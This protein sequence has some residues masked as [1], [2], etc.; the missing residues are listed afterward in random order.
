MRRSGYT[1]IDV[2]ASGSITAAAVLVVMVSLILGVAILS[3]S[4]LMAEDGVAAGE[5]SPGGTS[6]STSIVFP[7]T[8]VSDSTAAGDGEKGAAKEQSGFKPVWESTMKAGE[9]DVSLGTSMKTSY[10]HSSGWTFMNSVNVNKTVKRGRDMQR[11]NKN[12]SGTVTRASRGEYSVKFS[13]GENYNKSTS[14]GLARYGKALVMDKQRADAEVI[15]KKGLIPSIN[16][17]FSFKGDLKQGRDDFKYDRTYVGSASSFMGYH[18]TDQLMVNGSYGYSSTKESSDVG[19]ITFGGMPSWGD[20]MRTRVTYGKGKKKLVDFR[21]R[22]SDA[23]ERSVEPPRGQ[24]L[25]ILDDPSKAV[26]EEIVK[27]VEEINLTSFTQPLPYVSLEVQ[28][29]RS[30]NS[31]R[32]REEARMSRSNEKAELRAKAVYD[33][34]TSGA[35]SFTITNREEVNLKGEGSKSSYR[36]E[37]RELSAGINQNISK[38]SFISLRGTAY[39]TQRFFIVEQDNPRDEDRVFYKGQL[40]FQAE[41]FPSISTLISATADKYEIINI[42]ESFSG[43]NRVE[44]LYLIEPTIEFRPDSWITLQQDYTIRMEYTDY[45]YTADKNYLQRT[46]GL[47][48]SATLRVFKPLGLSFKYTYLL[49]D[50]GSYLDNERGIEVYSPYQENL[51]DGLAAALSYNFSKD[52]QIRAESKFRLK[53]RNQIGSSGGDFVVTSSTDYESG[54]LLLGFKKYSDLSGLGELDMDIAYIK[55]YGPYISEKRKEYWDV[56]ASLKFSF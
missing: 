20:T 27:E 19:D 16:S 30:I 12:L 13:L 34:S 8:S 55:N 10:L 42:D 22:Q 38:S 32:Y 28:F 25:Q 29:S 6:D 44:Y 26:Q 51:E 14:A 43:D 48:T 11:I 45:V 49:K 50:K 4:P 40:R 37:A 15:Y 46:T 7:D 36:E 21:Y 41:P 3:S 33:Y 23:V 9:V 5:Q 52:T 53:K 56:N 17:Q 35:A 47:N 18:I 31:K 54:T 1:I 39:I 2:F 24:S